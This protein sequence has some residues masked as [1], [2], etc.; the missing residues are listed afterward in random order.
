MG[1]KLEEIIA[2]PSEYHEVCV[3]QK[4]IVGACR[5]PSKNPLKYHLESLTPDGRL[6]R[7][8]GENYNNRFLPSKVLYHDLNPFGGPRDFTLV[9]LL[10]GI[11]SSNLPS[12]RR[13]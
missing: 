8:F 9:T 12:T 5:K 4:G 6:L 11:I 13:V 7:Q 1:V 2:V 3:D 10:G